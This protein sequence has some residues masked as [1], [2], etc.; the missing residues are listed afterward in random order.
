MN[1]RQKSQKVLGPLHIIKLYDKNVK[2]QVQYSSP[3]KKTSKD[4]HKKIVTLNTA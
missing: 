1:Y 3:S 2:V 4:S